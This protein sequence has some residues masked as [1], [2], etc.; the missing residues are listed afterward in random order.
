MTISRQIFVYGIVAIVAATLSGCGSGERSKRLNV[1]T[2]RAELPSIES[3]EGVERIWSQDIGDGVGKA[4]LDL[5]TAHV[6]GV[7]FAADPGGE[8]SAINGE[9]GKKNWTVDV[10]DEITA[11]VGAG[12]GALFVAD[13]EGRVHAIDAASGEIKW[14]V[15][16]GGEVLAPPVVS[17][18]TV[19]VRTVAGLVAGLRTSD[20]ERRWAYQR[21][22]PA[23]SLRGTAPPAVHEGVALTSFASGKVVANEI[24]TGTI[25]WEY[26]VVAPAG[27]NEIDRMVDL[28]ATPV[29]VGSVLYLAA[30]QSEVIALSLGTRQVLWRNDVSSFRDIAADDDSIYVTADDGEVIAFDRLTGERRWVQSALRGYSDTGPTVFGDVLLIGDNDG[31][32]HLLGRSSGDFV[33]RLDLGSTLVGPLLRDGDRI[34]ALSQDG[35]LFAY[36]RQPAG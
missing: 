25:L 15:N 32:L 2:E 28:D 1:E 16:A 17:T 22:V 14:S 29:L 24:E 10:G 11:G 31:R 21:T 8:V 23:L 20:G 33:G 7:V 30:F 3:D 9:D 4:Y 26:D 27:R 6:D 36:R 13:R 35:R 12:D 5:V 18:T 19:I 34:Y